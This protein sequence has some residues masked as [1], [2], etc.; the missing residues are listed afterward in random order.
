MTIA[1]KCFPVIKLVPLGIL[2]ILEFAPLSPPAPPLFFLNLTE[3][4]Y[5]APPYLRIN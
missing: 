5:K 1:L 3:G 2:N 4:P